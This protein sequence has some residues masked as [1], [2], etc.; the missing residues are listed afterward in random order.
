[1]S[2]KRRIKALTVAASHFE[3][4]AESERNDA[5]RL[6]ISYRDHLAALARARRAS[7]NAEILRKMALEIATK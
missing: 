2:K 5:E 1:M 4:D 7:A 3:L 6:G